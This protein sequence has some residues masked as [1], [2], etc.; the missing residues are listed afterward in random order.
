MNAYNEMLLHPFMKNMGILYHRQDKYVIDGWLNHIML[1][2][3][4][5]FTKIGK[6]KDKNNLKKQ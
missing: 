4:L 5:L 3:G 6:G 1:F 2:Q